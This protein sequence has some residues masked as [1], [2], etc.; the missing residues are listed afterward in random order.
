MGTVSYST[1]YYYERQRTTD[2]ALLA[3]LQYRIHRNLVNLF[4]TVKL[5]TIT[6]VVL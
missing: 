1:V 6:V 4:D 3:G 5:P 2:T